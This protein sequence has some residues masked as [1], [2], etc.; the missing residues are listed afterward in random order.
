MPC[1]VAGIVASGSF[2]GLTSALAAT[3]VFTPTT[4]G[5]F[6]LSVV[7]SVNSGDPVQIAALWNDGFNAKTGSIN[8]A[9]TT[10]GAGSSFPIVVGSGQAVQLETFLNSGPA[11]YDLYYTIQSL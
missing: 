4:G 2:I 6:L 9:S 5:P 10:S 8:T 1:S 7:G 11:T 3:T